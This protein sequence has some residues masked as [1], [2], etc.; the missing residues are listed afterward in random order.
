MGSGIARCL[1]VVLAISLTAGGLSVASAWVFYR[2]DRQR[3]YSTMVGTLTVELPEGKGVSTAVLVDGCGILTNF[4]AVFGPWYVTALRAP[5][6]EFPGTFTLT[7]ATRPDGTLPSARAIPVVWGD[8]RGPDRHWRIPH[9]DWAYLVLEQCLG[10]YGHFVLRDL[11][12]DEPAGAIDGFAAIGYSTGQ[13]MIDP[14]CSLQVA[15]PP[16]GNRGWRHDCALDAGDSGGPIL[17]RGT[18]TLVALGMGS[19]ADPGGCPSGRGRLGGPLARWTM[20]CANLA[21]PLTRDIIE[22]VEA[23]HVAVA[24]QRALDELGYDAGAL[25]AIDD[26]RA[27]AAIR[28][29]QREMGWA[30]TGEPGHPLLKILLLRLKLMVG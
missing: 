13:Q 1:A 17:W 23:A 6:R 5:S 28:Q 8:Y 7:E 18:L 11:D 24:V 26:P 2:D 29:V 25:G 3:S 12:L 27:S 15:P 16:G 4:H 22:R 20:G 30:V 19:V 9:H 10:L 21:V 14:V